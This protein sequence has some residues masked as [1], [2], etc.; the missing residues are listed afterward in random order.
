MNFEV[1]RNFIKIYRYNL[2]IRKLM[3][4]N[5]SSKLKADASVEQD[6]AV[7]KLTSEDWHCLL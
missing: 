3:H 1:E 6:S 5:T 4:A 2:E 7:R